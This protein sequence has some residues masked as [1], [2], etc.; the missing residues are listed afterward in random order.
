MT[1]AK[2]LLWR[3]TLSLVSGAW[4]KRSGVAGDDTDVGGALVSKSATLLA[5]TA[6]LFYYYD[7]LIEK[8]STLSRLCAAQGW[9]AFYSSKSEANEWN[10][11]HGMG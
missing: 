5:F 3:E 6:T 9:S 2:H 1:V 7:S 4:L 8:C 10:S 11:S